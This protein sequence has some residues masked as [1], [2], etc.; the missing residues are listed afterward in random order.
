M[1]RTFRSSPLRRYASVASLERR[2]RR[3]SGVALAAGL[4]LGLALPPLLG[5]AS[6]LLPA[7]PPPALELAPAAARA[8]EAPFPWRL[9]PPRVQLGDMIRANPG[10]QRRL[11][12]GG[13][14]RR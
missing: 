7:P 3:R 6:A 1:P 5:G 14:T 12:L 4:A 8:A 13:M 2:S 9:A 10:E 11:D